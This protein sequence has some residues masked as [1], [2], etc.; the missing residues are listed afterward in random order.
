MN[1]ATINSYSRQAA[2]IAQ[3]VTELEKGQGQ[4]LVT[5]VKAPPAYS[6]WLGEKIIVGRQGET[7]GA[8]PTGKLQEK[9]LEV[10]SQVWTSRLPQL[11]SIPVNE[12]GAEDQD[13][14][15]EV[16]LF[17]DP[18]FPLP[19]MII[20]GGGHVAQPLAA[21]AKMVGFQVTVIDDRPDF[22]SQERFPQADR[23]ICADFAQALKEIQVGPQSYLVIVTRGHQYDYFCLRET[24]GL[25]AAYIGMIGS[26]TKV[27][28][29]KK[30]LLE[31]GIDPELIEQVHAPI[32]INIG[33]ETPEEIAVSIMAEIIAIRR[34]RP[35]P[36]SMKA[37][38]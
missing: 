25:P 10:A 21:L 14:Q 1:A 27:R 19:E 30:R 23:I 18:I 12:V 34:G 3:L 32:G 8:L 2:I 5:I 7:A 11:A 4:V 31:E 22:A 29:T 26:R 6:S 36:G 13:D 16:V 24:I 38:S 33:A 28:G 15:E 17:A 20:L 9:A 37:S 35:A